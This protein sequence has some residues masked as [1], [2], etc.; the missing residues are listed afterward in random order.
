MGRP[1][2]GRR[3]RRRARGD[4]SGRLR[5][6]DT[7]SSEQFR[8]TATF[9]EDDGIGGDHPESTFETNHG[10][11]TVP[12]ES[13]ELL[14]APDNAA[15]RLEALIADA[16][17]EILIKQ[18]SI[19]ADVSVLEATLDAARRGVDVR[20]LLDSAWY[21]EEE[22]AALVNDLEAIAAD[23]ELALEAT[24]V[25][26]TDR[27]EKIHAKGVI[28]DREAAVVGSANWNENAFE[29]NRE[30]LLVLHGE[31]AAEY[32]AAVFEGDW[33]GDVWTL[34]I[35]LSLSAAAVLAV[36]ALVGWR[37][38]RFGDRRVATEE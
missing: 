20:I 12:V 21:H 7:R 33:D 36:A 6:W 16:D 8:S 9:V 11:E 13:V 19:A 4:V 35:G 18:A 3:D 31:S 1:S 34:P 5:G 17:D 24:V 25:D 26:R 38:V 10:A 32:Y 2:R 27:F 14:V 15:D 23:E 37:Y 22:N 29:N 28:V 30:V